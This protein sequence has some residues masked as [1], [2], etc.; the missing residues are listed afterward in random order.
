MRALFPPGFV[1]SWFAVLIATHAYG[2]ES[3][4]QEAIQRHLA[5]HGPIVEA[6]R[7][8]MADLDANGSAEAVVSYCITDNPRGEKNTGASNPAK[9]HCTVTVF[10]QKDA[11]WVGAGQ[12]KLGLGK[13]RDVRGGV[14]YAESVNFGP[15]DPLCCPSR[16][17]SRRLGLKK[18]KL[19][20]LR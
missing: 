4:L 14:I 3:G 15:N 13:V 2:Q 19:I 9:V 6:P 8:L 11:R 5:K 12:V 10:I 18:G 20:Q 16:K 17:V 7:T 1:A